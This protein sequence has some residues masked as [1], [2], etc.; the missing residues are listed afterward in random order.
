[1]DPLPKYLCLD[2]WTV[3]DRFHVFHEKVQRAQAKYL[4]DAVKVEQE[5]HFIDTLEPIHFEAVA[6]ATTDPIGSINLIDEEE[7]RTKV[8]IE[9]DMSKN[10]TE[11]VFIVEDSVNIGV[12]NGESIEDDH[13]DIRSSEPTENTENTDISG[14]LIDSAERIS[15]I[16]HIFC[17]SQMMIS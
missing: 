13:I 16:Y 5:N 1:M 10:E 2:C 8:K 7:N 3:V 14:L 12:E 4:S 11:P 15:C 6:P 9:Y 17:D